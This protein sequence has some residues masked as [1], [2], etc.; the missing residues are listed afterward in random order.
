M[1]GDEPT[2]VALAKFLQGVFPACAGMNRDS[3]MRYL[4]GYSVPRMRGDEPDFRCSYSS[5]GPVFPA[6]AGM[7]RM[8]SRTSGG[9]CCVPRMRGDEPGYVTA[10]VRDK[11]CSPHARG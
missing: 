11:L 9:S 10:A 8:S 6:C 4:N 7:N 5:A 2:D 1:R 3:F